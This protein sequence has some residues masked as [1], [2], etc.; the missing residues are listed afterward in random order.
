MLDSLSFVSTAKLFA[1]VSDLAPLSRKAVTNG[2]RFCQESTV[3]KFAS[4]NNNFASFS[5]CLASCGKASTLYVKILGS[6]LIYASLSVSL[7]G[8]Q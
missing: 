2:G 8:A 7:L 1:F 4:F 6:I 3:G 5:D